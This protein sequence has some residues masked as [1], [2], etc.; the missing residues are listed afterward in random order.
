MAGTQRSRPLRFAVVLL[1]LW[2]IGNP[3][4]GA[5]TA[6]H[7]LPGETCRGYFFV[8]ITLQA[9]EG[10]PD[11]DRTLWFIYD[12]G[13]SVSH[14]DPDSLERASGRRIPAGR[15]V[16]ITD[17]TAGPVTYNA[18]PAR[19]SELDHLSTALGREIDGILGYEAFG[20]TLVTLDYAAREIRLSAGRLPRPDGE[21]IFDA[22]GPDSRPWLRVDFAD[23]SRRMLI[24]SG[25]ALTVLTLNHL[26]RYATQRPPRATGGA[27][28]FDHVEQRE[29]ARLDGIARMGPHILDAPTVE[30]TDET[31]LIGGEVMRHFNWTFDPVTDRVRIEPHAAGE[32]V[33]FEPVFG[34]G[35]VLVP[36]GASMRVHAVLAD[37]PAERAGIRA[38][39]IV[40]GL[41]GR[42]LRERGCAERPDDILIVTLVREG[43]ERDV[44]LELF[45]LID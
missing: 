17:A 3:A 9:R 45:A 25:A 1:A 35:M 4:M 34:H 16:R 40:T 41:N 22:D 36:E 38:G 21:H 33:R 15:R 26:S 8:P 43:S 20:D 24:D 44:R 28:R 6:D 7:V 14:V 39:D 42:P 31:E 12:T 10:A 27:V 29:G 13:A 11:R 37:T 32:P 2:L 30:E 19:V 23:R 18:L 5:D